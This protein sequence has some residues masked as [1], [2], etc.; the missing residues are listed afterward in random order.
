MW[1]CTLLIVHIQLSTCSVITPTVQQDSIKSTAEVNMHV[2]TTISA[3]Q[4]ADFMGCKG[5]KHKISKWLNELMQEVAR[6]F[7]D[8]ECDKKNRH[9][10]TVRIACLTK[11]SY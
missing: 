9:A 6:I 11:V 3:A 7:N 2:S 5:V 1:L 8:Y 4:I 10:L